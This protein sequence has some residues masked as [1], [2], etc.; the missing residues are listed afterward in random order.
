MNRKRIFGILI[1]WA[2]LMA[3]LGRHQIE[4]INQSETMVNNIRTE[5]GEV[6]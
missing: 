1:L 6:R 2:V 5:Q 4:K 3:C